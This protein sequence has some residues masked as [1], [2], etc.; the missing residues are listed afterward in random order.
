M[1][2]TQ[3]SY[4]VAPVTTPLKGTLL[5]AATVQEGMAWLD[6]RD[7]FDSYNC[8]KFQAEAEFCAP[9]TKN[10]DQGAVWQDGFRFAVYGG[11]TCKAVGLDMGRMKAEVERVFAAGES[12]AVEQ[13]LMRQR[14]VADDSGDALW[15]APVDITPASGAV[16]P[17]VGIALLEGFASS[18][19]V[20]NPTIHMPRTIAALVLGV[21]GAEFNGNVL[22]TKLGSRVVAGAGY[23][24]PNTGPDG[25]PAAAGERWLY[26]TG[27]VV[28]ARGEAIIRDVIGQEDNDVFVLAER[29]Y[30]AAVDC[31]TAA[32]RVSVTG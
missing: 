9:N 3:V 2:M 11:V 31:F 10:F 15:G 5:D 28:I 6:G 8:M 22:E 17:G 18:E 13:A 25:T 32:V 16:K 12:T 4:P 30:I 7:L 29:G 23:D 1:T 14:F 26:A 27:G 24:Y 19:Y 21:D 20:G